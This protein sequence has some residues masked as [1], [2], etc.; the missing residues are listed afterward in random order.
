LQPGAESVPVA[1]LLAKR[2]F[3]VT[4]ERVIAAP[5]WV[6]MNTSSVPRSPLHVA[7]ARGSRIAV[8]SRPP[9][10]TWKLACSAPA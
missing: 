6:P 3:R 8:A 4:P 1:W 9:A 7:I 2:S 10:R 5:P